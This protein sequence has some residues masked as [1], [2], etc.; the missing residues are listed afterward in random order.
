[1]VMASFLEVLGLGAL[2]GFI[3]LLANQDSLESYEA[4]RTYIKPMGL[5]QNALLAFGGLALFSIF[6][7]KNVF[8]TFVQ[9]L[10]SKFTAHLTIDLSH[11]LYRSYL[12]AP[13]K[14]LLK[15][16]TSV[17]LHTIH[18][19]SRAV[20]GQVVGNFFNI[21]LNLV[22]SLSVVVLL[23]VS[24]AMMGLVVVGVLGVS[25]VLILKLLQSRM[26]KLGKTA[27]EQDRLCIKYINQG[28]EGYKEVKVTSAENYFL[29]KYYSSVSSFNF[30]DRYRAFLGSASSNFLE[31]LA[32][33]SIVLIVIALTY[34]GV[35]K[36]DLLP[37]LS[38][39]GAGIIRLRGYVTTVINN[40]ANL[41]YSVHNIKPVHSV[42]CLQDKAVNSK[43]FKEIVKF[44]MIKVKKLFF[45][46]SHNVNNVNNVLNGVSFEM[47]SG[48]S[49]AIV[50]ESGAGKTTFV[51]IF[52]NLL[53]PLS[54]H[55]EVDGEVVVGNKRTAS[56]S[57][58]YV[59]QEIFI[60]DDN[61]RRNVAFGVMDDVIDDDK[62]VRA[63]KLAQLEDFVNDLEDG[64]DT[65]VG[66][67]GAR[68]SGG[69]RQR[70][71]IARALYFE[72]KILV[73]D[74]ATSSL[75]N[76]TEQAFIKTLNDLKKSFTIIMIA[77]RLSTIK[78]CDKIIMLEMGKVVNE[79][80][81]SS[82]AE[83]NDKFKEMI[84]NGSLE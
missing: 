21:F 10:Q 28:L 25:G 34:L 31:Q 55:V 60:I 57:I 71:G 43:K 77:H 61:L 14:E 84:L 33:A 19:E 23:L 36:K 72:P 40:Y 78:I 7:L 37:M 50:G 64:L 9:Y 63:L 49:L 74:E 3:I 48:S 66:E 42:L 69:Q 47:K 76:I 20:A 54:G 68:I 13:Y 70:I 38:L 6:L 59:P 81:F 22:M 51:D 29:K 79:G 44:K 18:L 15:S 52:L 24:S 12:N 53:D 83:Q 8:L 35:E 32:V 46:Y 75:D 80:T 65:F 41:K 11:R 30:T 39:F 62:V 67:R 16:N 5:S 27:L 73:L 45:T 56:L 26:H 17:L 2:P 58:G 1:M 82:L 4:Y